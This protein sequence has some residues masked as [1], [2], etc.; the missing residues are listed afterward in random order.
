MITLEV[1]TF[2]LFHFRP[3]TQ[4]SGSLERTIMHSQ[5]RAANL[6][7]WLRRPDCPKFIKDIKQLV[8]QSIGAVNNDLVAPWQRES[9]VT[10]TSSPAHFCHR[11]YN[12]SKAAVHQGNATI[13]FWPKPAPGARPPPAVPALIEE[14]KSI[15]DESKKEISFVVRQYLPLGAGKR[16]PF[17][18]FPHL[19]A[20]TFSSSLSCTTIN[21]SPAQVWSHAACY[22]FSHDRSVFVNLSRD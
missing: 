12:Y 14:I 21:I 8:D 22:D 9:R 19:Q 5:T 16:D 10:K 1:S 18:R 2:L 17:A 20:S 4:S 11:G 3:I 13:L 15:G 7:G 6:R